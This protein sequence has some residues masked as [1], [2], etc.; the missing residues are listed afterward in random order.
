MAMRR[1]GGAQPIPL[2]LQI[3]DMAVRF[4]GLCF[5]RR[6]RSWY[7]DLQPTPE[8]PQYR[9]RISYRLPLSPKV[10]VRHPEIHPDAKHR[11]ADSSLCLYDPRVGE[12]HPD[13]FLSQTIV[14][15]T[16]EWLFYYEAWLLDTQKRWFGPEAPHGPL[17]RPGR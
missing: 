13:L 3:A 9:V 2:G 7:G 16:A 12:W 17:K 15:W 8:S 6:Q 10:W 1:R 11:Y 14:P 4:P 5:H